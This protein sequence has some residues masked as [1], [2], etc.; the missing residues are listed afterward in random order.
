MDGLFELTDSN[1]R[2]ANLSDLLAAPDQ[3]EFFLYKA[4]DIRSRGPEWR[5]LTLPM[6]PLKHLE[7]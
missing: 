6:E 2:P 4:Q 5:R 7:S 1:G 3:A